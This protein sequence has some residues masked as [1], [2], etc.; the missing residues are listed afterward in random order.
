MIVDLRF[1]N[2]KHNPQLMEIYVQE[3]LSVFTRIKNIHLFARKSDYSKLNY[4]VGNFSV[5]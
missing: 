5:Y 4:Q 2:F 3:D 1:A